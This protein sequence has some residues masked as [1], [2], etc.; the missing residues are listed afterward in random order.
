MA[1]LCNREIV[2]FCTL[3]GAT[4]TPE[5]SRYMPSPNVCAHCEDPAIPV[6]GGNGFSFQYKATAEVAIELHLHDS[7]AEQWATAFSVVN[8]TNKILA[9]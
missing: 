1:R 5:V 4:L 3:Q 9:K 2:Y 7:C 6:L 8:P